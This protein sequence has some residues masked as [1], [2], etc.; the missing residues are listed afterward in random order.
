[1]RRRSGCAMWGLELCDADVLDGDSVVV[2]LE[3]IAAT[4][5]A[6]GG[7]AARRRLSRRHALGPCREGDRT[8]QGIPRCAGARSPKTSS[9]AA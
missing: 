5:A 9:T 1:M 2:R 4:I 3:L 7:E 8:L 6:R